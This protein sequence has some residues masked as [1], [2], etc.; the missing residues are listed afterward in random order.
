ME[1]GG[2]SAQ[3]GDMR[4][5][6]FVTL[7]EIANE[8]REKD[9]SDQIERMEKQMETLTTILH[10]LRSER[11]GT[12]EERVRSGGVTPGHNSTRSQ[13]IRRFGDERCHLSLRGEIH[14]EEEQSPVGQIF[15]EGDG[16]ANAEETEI[17]QHLHDVE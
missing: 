15:Y 7:R 9:M 1:A 16:V 8:A 13:T 17:R 11:R 10:E 6:D 5:N 4:L 2:S 3:G 14:K 12:H